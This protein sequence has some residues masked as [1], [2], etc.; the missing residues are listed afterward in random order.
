MLRRNWTFL[1]VAALAVTACEG[2][3]GPAGPSGTAGP[4]GA[5]GSAG[6]VGPAGQDANEN[7][8]Q[9]HT[10]DVNMFAKQQQLLNAGH[11][12]GQYVRDSG[13]CAVCHTHQ[14]FLERLETGAWAYAA[15]SVDDVVPMNCRTCHQ[16]HTTYTASD[17]TLTADGI[18]VEFRLSGESVDFGNTSNLCASCHQARIRSGQMA[19]EDGDPVTFTSTHYGGHYGPQGNINAGVGYYFTGSVGGMM[20]HQTDSRSEGCATC[21]MAEGSQTAG[22]HTFE[23]GSNVAGC[24][25]CHSSV[26]DFD[27]FG[28]QTDVQALIDE[29]GVLI[30]ASHV[31]HFDGEAWHPIPGTFPAN[32]VA[33]W[34]NFDA[35]LKDGSLGVHNPAYVKAMLEGAIAAMQ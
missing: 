16:I 5:A 14:G 32:T 7:C 3:E 17:Y 12:P 33:A 6:P 19:V 8:T 21:H 20:S 30:E 29:L 2:P 13:E 11:G 28:Q 18:P 35:V 31:A 27:K 34:W 26:D 25:V 9:C 23:M 22:G 24:E 1:I 15:G 10:G 4:A